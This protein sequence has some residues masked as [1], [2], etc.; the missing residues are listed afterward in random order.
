[1]TKAQWTRSE[2]ALFAAPIVCPTFFGQQTGAFV[3]SLCFALSRDITNI[4][5]SE[6]TDNS[7][8]RCESLH[9]Q[10]FTW[11][12]L[13]EKNV[14]PPLH[15]NCKCRL[16]A[17]DAA[18]EYVYNLNRDGFIRQL[19]LYCSE[20]SL[21]DGGVYLL[22]HDTLGGISA[23]ALNAL[24]LFSLP[25]ITDSENRKPKW[26]EGIKAWAKKLRE[27]FSATVDAFFDRG[28]RLLV[29]AD[30]TMDSNPLLG[31]AYW[32]D[33]LSFGI[34]SGLYENWQRNYAI[35]SED[36]Q[37]ITLLISTLTVW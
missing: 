23:H 6:R 33:A 24:V 25:A 1:M 5:F 15:P 3:T 7:C 27:D 19:D 20:A 30:E 8:M 26:Y 18:A 12:E 34:V 9:G 17:M 29:N 4:F 13:A 21:D 16:F 14:I 35:W 10:M 11:E 32:A 28:Q 36:P 22:S 37:P 31:M 2:K